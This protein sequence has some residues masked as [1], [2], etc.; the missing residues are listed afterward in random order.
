MQFC[1]A[2]Q[3]L[4][5]NPVWQQCTRGDHRHRQ[6]AGTHAADQ[7]DLLS[8]R[9]LGPPV[10]H[11]PRHPS[12]TQLCGGS[13]PD[14]RPGSCPGSSRGDAVMGT[15]PASSAR[16]RASPAVR[17]RAHLPGT[18]PVNRHMW[19]LTSRIGKRIGPD[20]S[21]WL[22]VFSKFSAA[23]ACPRVGALQWTF[24]QDTRSLCGIMNQD[25]TELAAGVCVFV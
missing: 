18:G 11:Q 7:S 4:V 3:G 9:P 19:R 12:Y 1:L 20:P 13:C 16:A 5:D 15:P 10:I 14:S 8:H 21:Q 22:L 6:R 23:H 24:S 25:S 17:R 2:L